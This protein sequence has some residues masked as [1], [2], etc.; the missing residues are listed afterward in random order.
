MPSWAIVGFTQ[1]S[2]D[3][4]G[5]R[6]K[7]G[8]RAEF[9]GIGRSLDRGDL[10]NSF[11]QDPLDSLLQRLGARGA[12]DARSEKADS[13]EPLTGDIDELDIA[14]IF[15]NCGPHELEDLAN[16]RLKVIFAALGHLLF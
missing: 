14:L 9:L 5:Q 7:S 10:W 13:N 16:A 2:G 12:A 11:L 6:Q 3:F 4:L 8:G 15:A 1:L